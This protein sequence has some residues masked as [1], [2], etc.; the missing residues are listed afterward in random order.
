MRQTDRQTS[1][2]TGAQVLFGTAE[3]VAGNPVRTAI[4]APVL[5]NRI[6]SARY[7]AVRLSYHDSSKVPAIQTRFC[8][9]TGLSTAFVFV[10]DTYICMPNAQMQWRV[11]VGP[12]IMVLALLSSAHFTN[13]EH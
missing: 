13:I 10:G 6:R 1:T 9:V 7:P 2:I 8:F 11:S 12:A 5:D 3:T 4:P